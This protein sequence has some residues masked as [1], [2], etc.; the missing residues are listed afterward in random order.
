[1][2]DA[3]RSE[4]EA[5]EAIYD[6]PD[7]RTRFIESGLELGWPHAKR[8]AWRAWQ[9]A[10]QSAP[11]QTPAPQGE[12]PE[13]LSDY[14]IL[15]IGRKHF[16]PD[17]EETEVT[18]AAFIDAV[19]DCIAATPQ[20]ARHEGGEEEA[21]SWK[22]VVKAILAVDKE[23]SRRG[24][25]FPQTSDEQTDDRRAVRRVINMLDFYA[26]HGGSV[27]EK[28]SD[29]PKI[30]AAP[31]PPGY[32]LVPETELYDE[33]VYCFVPREP[34]LEMVAAPGMATAMRSGSAA[35]IYRAMIAAAPPIAAAKDVTI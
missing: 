3:N 24:E 33:T 9:A 16:R 7:Y 30:H 19:R 1:M 23:A 13:P 20:G 6:S 17:V 5:F 26:N 14:Q 32:V 12:M 25:M 2:S 22:D 18:Q 35:Q 27:A 31:T 4:F 28:L 29:W 34:T 11:P 21:I 10:R 8:H 15:A